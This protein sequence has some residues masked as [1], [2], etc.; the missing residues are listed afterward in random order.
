MMSR[1]ECLKVYGSDYL[2]DKKIEK[3][4]LYKITKGIYSE[5]K[6]IPDLA[7][8]SYKYPNA[9]ITMKS[10]FYF[11]NLTDVIPDVCDLATSRDAAKIRDKKVKQYFVSDV[12]F[13]EGIETVD[14]KGF[15]IHIYSK[16]RMLIEL[17][18]YKSKLSFDYYKEVILN[19]RNILPQLNIQ[20]IQDIALMAPKSNKIMETLQLEVF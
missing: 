19:Y 20:E 13:K 3:G 7:V 18:R 2:I 4:E 14:Y 8:F 9:V 16:E 6:Y 15:D 5:K 10:A 12:F 1:A 17:V 11:Y